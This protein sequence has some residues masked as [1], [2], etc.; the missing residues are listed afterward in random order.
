MRT[1]WVLA[2]VAGMLAVA[3][4]VAAIRSSQPRSHSSPATVSTVTKAFAARH[5]ALEI[6]GAGTEGLAPGVPGHPM[7]FLSNQ[8]ASGQGV[9]Q[10]VVLR[11]TAEALGVIRYGKR[12]DLSA[13]DVCGRTL[14]VDLERLQTRNVVVTFSRCDYVD[15]PIRLAPASAGSIVAE[16]MRD[17]S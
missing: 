7:A 6:D 1:R 4:V 8:P 12:L 11:S 13:T 17:L 2:G 16:V 15:K 14:A 5:I 3:G 9:V 10:V